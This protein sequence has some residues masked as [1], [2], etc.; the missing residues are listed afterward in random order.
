MRAIVAS[1]VVLTVTTAA[2]AD[3][4]LSASVLNT[5]LKTLERLRQQAASGTDA[6]RADALFQTGVEADRLASLVNDEIASHGMQER[7]LIELAMTRTKE[8]GISIAYNRDKKKFFYDGAAFREY[9][10][11]APKGSHAADA[12]FMVLSYQFYQSAGT[13]MQSL[14]AAADAKKQFLAKY[15]KFKGNA[16]V[17]LLLAVD[18]RDLYRLYRDGNEA[19]SAEKYRR[20]TRATY[21]GLIRRYPGTEQA[22]AARGLL[23]RFDEESAHSPR[24]DP[25]D[26]P[27]LTDQP[28][29]AAYFVD[30]GF[31]SYSP[32]GTMAR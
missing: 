18:Y 28:A 24:P 10:K 26:L 5:T 9:L 22:D 15:P 7:E 19:A 32:R 21:Q 31:S 25:P 20:L 6:Q 11:A 4:I 29:P 23:R 13:D 30:G 16:E 27:R 17:S 8:L 1:F 2:R 14:A 12:E 3:I